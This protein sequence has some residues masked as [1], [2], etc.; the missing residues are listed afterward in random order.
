YL[1]L[2]REV[3]VAFPPEEHAAEAGLDRIVA[4]FERRHEELYGF[5]SP[6]R[7]LEVINLRVSVYGRRRPPLELVRP[8]RAGVK[9]PARGTRP[10]YLPALGEMV[11][12]CVF[13]GDRMEPGQRVSGP[14]VVEEA[15]TT[16]VVPDDFDLVVD[17]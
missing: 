4:G 6:G 14:A 12:V 8:S 10:V 15:T 7:R 17:R 1:G 5:S 13:D 16:I 9:A 11:E 2:H 3:V